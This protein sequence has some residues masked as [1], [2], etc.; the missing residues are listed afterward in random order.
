MERSQRNDGTALLEGEFQGAHL[1]SAQE[2]R[3]KSIV[4]DTI[5]HASEFLSRP[6]DIF[7][8]SDFMKELGARLSALK[9]ALPSTVFKAAVDGLE[10]LFRIYSST[11]W[12]MHDLKTLRILP[13]YEEILLEGVTVL[14]G[15]DRSLHAGYALASLELLH[16]NE[17]GVPVW[18]D[19][20]GRKIC[21]RWDDAFLFVR[22]STTLVT[23]EALQREV[24]GD[25]PL[26][27]DE[28]E[29]K[30]FDAVFETAKLYLDGNSSKPLGDVKASAIRVLRQCLF[31]ETV[32]E[33]QKVARHLDEAHGLLEILSE[34]SGCTAHRNLIYGEQDPISPE[35]LGVYLRIQEE[36]LAPAGS[37]KGLKSVYSIAEMERLKAQPGSFVIELRHYREIL[38]FAFLLSDRA[39]F[40]SYA[41][42]ELSRDG[43]VLGQALYTAIVATTPRANAKLDADPNKL[44]NT[45]IRDLALVRRFDSLF[46]WTRADNT[47]LLAHVAAGANIAGRRPIIDD[48]HPFDAVFLGA[49]IMQKSLNDSR[50]NMQKQKA[51]SILR[52]EHRE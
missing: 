15:R 26:S 5:R 39:T 40:P 32:A 20:D 10:G 14:A 25:A 49:P 29:G 16:L 24:A 37:S 22:L 43:L 1:P 21:Q 35:S 33:R 44:I 52:E 31:P 23:I 3:L 7:E 47:A 41:A 13:A 36:R 17:R 9:E 18:M 42:D 51:R 11:D 27:K 4:I 50:R 2:I 8:F 45:A 19:R 28:F 12:Q 30:V 48:G 6:H 34:W 38:G 46:G